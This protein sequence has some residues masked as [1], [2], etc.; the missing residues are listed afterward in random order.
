MKQLKDEELLR[1]AQQVHELSEYERMKLNKSKA[2]IVERK[3]EQYANWKTNQTIKN[4]RILKEN[5]LENHLTQ[6]IK[7]DILE[8]IHIDHEFHKE[9]NAYFDLNCQKLGVEMK[10]D[11]E[12]KNK[13]IFLYIF[14]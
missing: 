9:S 7:D 4:T 3:A 11:P 13:R 6:Q 5:Q 10:H 1:E 8:G 2:Y 12:R 14:I